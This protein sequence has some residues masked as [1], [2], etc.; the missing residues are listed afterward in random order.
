[1]REKYQ[2][3]L[4]NLLHVPTDEQNADIFTKALCRVKFEKFRDMMGIVYFNS[5]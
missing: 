1:M 4:F 2:E 5:N 3:K